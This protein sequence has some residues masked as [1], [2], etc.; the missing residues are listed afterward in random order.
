MLY[1]S[2]SGLQIVNSEQCVRP[3]CDSYTSATWTT[4]T[5]VIGTLQVTTMSCMHSK[6]LLAWTLDRQLQLL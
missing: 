1:Q 5:M 4:M 2:V 6:D 3:G